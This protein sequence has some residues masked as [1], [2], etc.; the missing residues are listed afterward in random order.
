MTSDRLRRRVVPTT[1]LRSLGA[2]FVVASGLSCSR[3]PP[4]RAAQPLPTLP[5]ARVSLPPRLPS[6]V[7]DSAQLVVDEP[8]ITLITGDGDMDVRQALD[9]IAMRGHYSLAMSPSLKG[10]VRLRLENVP[11]SEALQVVLA[12]AN[13]TLASLPGVQTTWDP[14]TVFFQLPVNVDSLSAEAIVKRFGVSR[15]VAELIVRARRP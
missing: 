15:E 10:R 12:Q 9:A 13:L 3:T 2:A 7:L 11:V 6:T 5:D 14:S 4:P 1:G 8:R